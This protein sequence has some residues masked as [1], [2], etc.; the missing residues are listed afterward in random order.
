MMLYSRLVDALLD[1]CIA[2]SLGGYDVEDVL[3]DRAAGGDLIREILVLGVCDPR[4]KESVRVTKAWRDEAHGMLE[5][6]AQDLLDTRD[7][8]RD[9]ALMRLENFLSNLIFTAVMRRRS[10]SGEG[11]PGPADA[12]EGEGRPRVETKGRGKGNEE[13]LSREEERREELRFLKSIPPSLRKLARLIG[14]SGGEEKALSGRFPAAAKSDIAGITTGDD[15]SNLLPT[16]IALLAGRETEDVFFRHFVEKR[17]QVFASA[18]ASQG[19]VL[20]QDGPVVICLDRSGSME[21]RPSAVARA[22]AMAVT[23]IAKRRHRQVIIVRYGNDE[24]DSFAVKSLRKQR[25]ALNEFLSYGC[26]GGNN[27]DELF[28]TVFREL[29]P[30][31]KE[32]SC[33]DIL[34]VSDFFWAPVSKSV[35]E[36]IHAN[37]AKGMKFY[38]LAISLS[39]EVPRTP[40]VDSMWVWNEKKNLCYEMCGGLA[41]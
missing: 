28:G 36:L 26:A 21:G 7:L 22:L 40:I 24:L 2:A 35:L 20:R 10:D 25:R 11:R 15:L 4:F 33:A 30:R 1:E 39:G 23:I 12:G 41:Q 9:E 13:P 19:P 38:G 17:L 16:E 8:S 18:S 32:F 3:A 6:F 27:E 29:I 31:D 14:R 5:T 34:C 37:K